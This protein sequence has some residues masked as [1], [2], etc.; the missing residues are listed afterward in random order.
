[1]SLTY[2]KYLSSVISKNPNIYET[3]TDD[4]NQYFDIE[5]QTIITIAPKNKK[6]DNADDTKSYIQFRDIPATNF[7]RMS[8]LML[9]T[10]KEDQEEFIEDIETGK[11]IDTTNDPNKKNKSCLTNF[12]NIVISSAFY[13]SHIAIIAFIIRV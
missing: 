6:K 13:I 9:E 12:K 11:R 4:W 8:D 5:M 3:D 2:N 1:M 10:I 7:F